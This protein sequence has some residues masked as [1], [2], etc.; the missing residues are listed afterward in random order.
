[1]GLDLDEIIART[2]N[3]EKP[4]P[5]PTSSDSESDLND[6]LSRFYDIVNTKKATVRPKQVEL[7][8]TQQ[9]QR[10][11]DEIALQF[12]RQARGA[13]EKK[14]AAV[15]T[16]TDGR[17]NS[18]M[19]GERG[20]SGATTT[21]NNSKEDNEATIK[22]KRKK[23]KDRLDMDRIGKEESLNTTNTNAHKQEKRIPRVAKDTLKASANLKSSW[24]NFTNTFQ[25]TAAAAEQDIL[26]QL[27]R[28]SGGDLDGSLK[29]SG[30]DGSLNGREDAKQQQQKEEEEEIEN[31]ESEAPKKQDAS[32]SEAKIPSNEVNDDGIDSSYS[33]RSLN[34]EGSS[35]ADFDE[36]TKMTTSDE[37]KVNNNSDSNPDADR[38]AAVLEKLRSTVAVASNSKFKSLTK[39]V[40]AAQ[41]TANYKKEGGKDSELGPSDTILT[42]WRDTAGRISVIEDDK[43]A[44]G[45][46]NTCYGLFYDFNSYTC[47]T[48][49]HLPL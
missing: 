11:T 9:Q 40:I 36:K 6:S 43:E 38:E 13:V 49:T 25:S 18:G 12:L 16:G 32:G 2:K 4:T 22:S 23:M 46:C 24:T 31:L 3:K 45:E 21:N 29:N 47:L 1:M 26:E 8:D 44:I 42:L 14:Q 20:S 35:I 48:S 15:S 41:R 34:S 27:R 7:D 28:H 39:K 33:S 10:A 30:V 5:V 17:S 19:R 37:I